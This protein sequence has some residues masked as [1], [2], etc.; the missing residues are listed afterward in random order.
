MRQ[1]RVNV[2]LL[3]LMVGERKVGLGSLLPI[4]D[5]KR[6]PIQNCPSA[7][8]GYRWH[9]RKSPSYQRR[10]GKLQF[11]LYFAGEGQL[12]FI[13]SRLQHGVFS[14]GYC[15][16]LSHV[17]CLVL[18]FFKSVHQHTMLWQETVYWFILYQWSICKS[19]MMESLSHMIGPEDSN[20]IEIMGIF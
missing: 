3:Q 9:C 11:L 1:E 13:T 17:F 14:S 6:N 18:I 4:S 20:L 7:E 15:W 2:F 12:S 8:T 16:C 5:R 19:D 10:P